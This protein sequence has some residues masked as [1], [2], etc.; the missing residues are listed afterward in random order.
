MK[1]KL[2]ILLLLL[3]SMIYNEVIAQDDTGAY[4]KR[5][6]ESAEIDFLSSFYIQNGDN[7]AVSGGNGTEKLMDATASIVIAIPL[8]DDDVLTIDAGISA[9][10]S[11]SSSNI[12][13]FDG[14]EPADP[15]VASSGASE[16][17]LWFNVTGGYSH[18]SDDRNEIWSTKLSISS[19]FDYFSAGVGGNYA[20]L[21][22]DKNT[23]L[24]FN[25]NIYIDSWSLISPIELRSFGGGDSDNFNI[26]QYTITG[27][28]DYNPSYT[29]FEKSG[30]YSYSLGI[31]LSQILSKR[32]QG[33]VALDFVQQQGLLSTPFQRVYF[34]DI[35]D[36]F[37]ENFHLADNVEQLPGTRFK[38][39][40]G[41]R[42][43][44]YINEI[45][46]LRTYYRYYFDDW[47]IVSHTASVE[48]PVKIS[49]KYTFY[50]SFRFY[51]QTAADYFAPYEQH[52]SSSEFYTS[53]YDLSGYKAN[54]YGLG[55]NYT[56]IFMEKHIWKFGLKSVDVKLN[57]YMRDSGFK[58]FMLSAGC[59]FV[60]Y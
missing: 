48:L 5:V 52:L 53:D 9:Y 44:F 33:S 36:S 43:N 49:L 45:F 26:N 41:G 37:I 50:P 12:N 28:P 34:S 54:Q 10:S 30:R 32:M 22:N 15:F 16:S 25:G 38:V 18:S 24:S 56:D 11:A 58:A 27:N 20:R 7:A 19:E 29:P 59:K 4:K 35:E 60:W 2:T 47:G 1:T 42:L 6:L 55:L 21:F 31:G 46:V 13:P 17:D 39:A 14:S 40:S 23:E 3:A 8:N 51:N 57:A